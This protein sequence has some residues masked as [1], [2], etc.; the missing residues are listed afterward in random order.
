[1]KGEGGKPLFMCFEERVSI[2]NE[3][4]RKKEGACR[5]SSLW[6]SS[7]RGGRRGHREGRKE[8]VVSYH[9]FFLLGKK[10]KGEGGGRERTS[11]PVCCYSRTRGERGERKRG[12][13]GVNPLFSSMRRKR[14]EILWGRGSPYSFFLSGAGEGG[15]REGSLLSLSIEER[16]GRKEGEERSFHSPSEMGRVLRKGKGGRTNTV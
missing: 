16:G 3:E 10:G 13:G 4:K 5:S 11:G 2:S 6:S 14:K 7:E 8:G 15:G 9:L 12:G 1:M